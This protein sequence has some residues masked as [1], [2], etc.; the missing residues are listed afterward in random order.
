MATRRLSDIVTS[1]KKIAADKDLASQWR[2]LRKIG[3]Y[4]TK[5][6]P[7]IS[8]LTKS[9]R[10]AIRQ[11]FS[12]LQSLGRYEA[13]EVYRPAHKHEFEKTYTKFDR[14]GR[15]EKISKRK[16][17]RYEID[18]DHFQVLN[19]KPKKVPTGALKTSK[20]FITP[21]GAGEKV[22]L[23]KDG[24]VQT[25]EIK[26]KARTEFTREPLSGPTDFL[27]LI[28]DIQSGRLKFKDNEGL[29]LWSNGVRSVYYGQSAVSKMIKRLSRYSQG[30]IY[31][32]RGGLGNF[33]DWSS[34]SEIAH[35]RRR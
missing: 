17:S 35:V 23:T 9:R 22:R 33:D 13:G 21:K 1:R 34:N 6:T 28:D 14:L 3:V 10:A 8:R 27:T 2:L 15:I 26:D 32:G 11:K 12:E 20:G 4:Q 7:A 19:K 18:T 31:R 30:D 16:L 25:V 29:A 24:K 5:D